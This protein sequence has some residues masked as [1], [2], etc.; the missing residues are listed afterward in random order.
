[1][2][3][4][5]A[6]ARILLSNARRVTV[7]TGA[8]MSAES[9]IPTFRDALSG[10][11]S[12]FDPMTLASEEGFRADPGLVWRWYAE[13]RV[14]VAHAAPNE[15]HRALA[16]AAARAPLLMPLTLLTQNVDGLHQRAG[17]QAL[18]LHG[19]LVRT[20]CLARCGF[21]EDEPD[22]L[23]AGEPPACPQCGDW[24]RPAVVWFGEALD[25]AVLAR[26]ER[27]SESCDLMLV[28]GTSGMVF[29]AAS[30]P[31]LARAAGAAVVIL[32]P[33]AS[34]LDGVA[35]EVVRSTAALGLPEL[36]SN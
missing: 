16:Q 34:D 10:L 17:S 20:I 36:F 32:N 21:A 23:P 24:L 1:M 15:G 18:E 12:R 19:S 11:W 7:L 8:G 4:A 28:V 33:D 9:G 26:A 22:R 25:P 2:A 14:R 5:L 13:R 29:P 30:L 6:R 27:A 31:R 3:S 35:S